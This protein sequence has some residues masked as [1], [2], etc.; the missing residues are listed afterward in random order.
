MVLHKGERDAGTLLIVATFRQSGARLY[1]RMPSLDGARKFEITKHQDTQ[2]PS[3]FDE[4]LA[5]R[6]AQDPDIWVLEVDVADPEPLIAS[7][8]E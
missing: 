2:N 8:S 7:L 5:R 6:S 1:E 3:E 4:Y